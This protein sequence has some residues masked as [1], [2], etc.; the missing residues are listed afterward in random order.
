[1]IGG[2]AHAACRSATQLAVKPGPSAV[3]SDRGGRPCAQRAF[4]H[5]QHGGRRHVAVVGDDLALVIE[6]ALIERQR[7]LQRGDD[8]CAAGMADE[9]VDVGHRQ[10]PSAARI[11][12][13]AGPPCVRATKSGNR[14]LEDHAEPFGIDAPSHDVERIRPQLLAGALDPRR[15]AVAGAQHARRGAVAEQAGGDDIGLGQFVV[16]NAPACTVRARP[17]ARW[18]RAAPAPAAMR[19]TGPTRRPRSPGRT[20]ARA[21]RRQRKPSWPATRA[22]RLGVAMPVEQT[23]T[24][25]SISPADEIGARERLA[26]DIDEQRFRAFE[27]GLRSLRPAAR[28]EIPFDRLDA[29]AVADSGVGKQARKRFEL[30]IALGHHPARRFEDLALM[31]LMRGNRGRQRNQRGR[32]DH[33]A[34]PASRALS[35]LIKS[36]PG[37]SLL[38]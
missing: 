35:V 8:F 38:F 29:V 25:V 26:R 27:K 3:S 22:S 34:V 15:A 33:N 37:S 19:S 21:T 23:V 20:P 7:A 17:A 11:S 10:A 1:M 13:T 14:A 2:E 36:E 6:R 4:Q 18:C 16:A 9:A 12:A 31:K 32:I 28:L 5:E 24:T 30:R